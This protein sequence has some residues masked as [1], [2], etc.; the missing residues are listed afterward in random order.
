[1]LDKAFA[2]CQDKKEVYIPQPCSRIQLGSRVE[3]VQIPHKVILIEEVVEL[4][5]AEFH[6]VDEVECV[7]IGRNGGD[8]WIPWPA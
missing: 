4:P 2:K 5:A 8:V 6:D 1:M 3:L 7:V